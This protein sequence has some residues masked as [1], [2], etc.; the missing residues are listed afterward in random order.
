M[1]H[2]IKHSDS[3]K[4]AQKRQAFE[5]HL[6][7]LMDRLYS[8]ALSM[9][10]DPLDAEDLVQTTYLKAHRHFGQFKQ[11]SN[12]RAWMYR[13]LTNNFINEYRKKKQKPTQVDFEK[14]VAR[15]ANDNTR[16]VDSDSASDLHMEYRELFD[17]SITAALDKLP[18]HYRIPVL[19][20][21][22]NEL[23]YREIAEILHCPIGTV[24][25]R[26]R[27]GRQKLASS[28]K[29]YAAANGYVKTSN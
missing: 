25:S 27:R 15:W 5:T 7:P 19:L 8:T 4:A 9:T 26:I 24:M 20:C 1:K 23:K 3:Q 6:F 13:I 16:E 18:E 11:G 22:M 12:F 2:S 21:D 17:D 14:T 29:D 10:K 28:L